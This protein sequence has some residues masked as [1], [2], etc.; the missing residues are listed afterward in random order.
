M[1]APR[2]QKKL[3]RNKTSAHPHKRSE[4]KDRGLPSLQANQ[5]KIPLAAVLPAWLE[6]Y[7]EFDVPSCIHREDDDEMEKDD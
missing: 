6:D 5:L 1:A 4:W 3:H 2:K 7:P